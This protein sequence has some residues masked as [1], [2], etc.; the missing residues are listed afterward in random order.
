MKNNEMKD[1]AIVAPSLDLGIGVMIKNW[2]SKEL[3][4]IL[5]DL[6]KDVDLF[7]R[8]LND[9]GDDKA[10]TMMFVANGYFKIMLGCKDP[11]AAFENLLPTLKQYQSNLLD[12]SDEIELDPFELFVQINEGEPVYI[13]DLI[14]EE[15]CNCDDCI[16]RKKER[17]AA[18]AGITG[19][20]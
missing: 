11:N 14:G 10:R 8:E 2:P 17:E 1:D 4:L 15:D 6:A 12:I 16:K 3:W 5:Q 20:I 13:V 9:G 7:V 18:K 19:M